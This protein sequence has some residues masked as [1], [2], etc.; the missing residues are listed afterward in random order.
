MKNNWFYKVNQKQTG[1][2][3]L[4][5]PPRVH[6]SHSPTF[7]NFSFLLWYFFFFFFDGE[8][9]ANVCVFIIVVFLNKKNFFMVF[10]KLKK[11]LFWFH[12]G[13]VAALAFSSWDKW[14]LLFIAV[15]RLQWLWH[16]GL[17]ASKPVGFPQTRDWTCVPCIGKQILNHWTT[18]EVRRVLLLMYVEV[19]HILYCDISK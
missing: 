7:N 6:S 4:L 11:Y 16:R 10:K 14:S 15:H 5:S 17:V 2:L 9:A 1:P 19:F 18:R 12:W 3:W 13:F 8:N